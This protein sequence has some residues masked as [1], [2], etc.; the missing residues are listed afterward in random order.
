M[1]LKFDRKKLDNL[2][3]VGCSYVMK[4]RHRKF[5]GKWRSGQKHRSG[6]LDQEKTV[7][8]S[9]IDLVENS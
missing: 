6:K 3:I 8:V 9:N 7:G 5:N 4:W 2:S 1:A